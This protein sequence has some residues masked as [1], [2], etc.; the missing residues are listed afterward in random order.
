MEAGDF[1]QAG[2]KRGEGVTLFSLHEPSPLKRPLLL[3]SAFVCMFA[4][5][6][7]GPCSRCMH[8][9]HCTGLLVT[10][11]SHLARVDMQASEDLHTGANARAVSAQDVEQLLLECW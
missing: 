7:L 3:G 5:A 11:L 4:H 6:P 2:G 9:A 8:S 10:P 1:G